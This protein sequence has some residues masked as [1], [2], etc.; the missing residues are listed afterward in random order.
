MKRNLFK[1]LIVTGIMSAVIGIGGYGAAADHAASH[2]APHWSYEGDHGPAHWGEFGEACAEGKRQSPVNI[3]GA[4]TSS[5]PNIDIKYKPSK[6]NILNNGHTIQVNYEEGSSIVLDASE[7]K[8]L[9]FHFHDPSEHTVDG[10]SYGM[11]LHL[12]HKND[13]GDLAVIGVLIEEGKENNAFKQIW[14]NMPKKADEKK[15]V[16]GASIDASTLLPESLAYYT[17]PGSLTTPPCTESVTWL[18]LKEPIQMSAAQIK[19]FKKLINVNN[20]P[21][22]PLNE[23]KINTM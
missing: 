4:E 1:R 12:V 10:K 20:R 5:L 7:Y 16:K 8:L 23:R 21:I 18:V 2:A 22:Q 9:Q 19:A 3:T 17:Y 13:N 6:L 15:E 14:A 11:E